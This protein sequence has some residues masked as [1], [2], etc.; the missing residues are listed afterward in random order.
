MFLEPLKHDTS[1]TPRSVPVCY[2]NNPLE[3]SRQ[4]SKMTS[5]F[6][7]RQAKALEGAG[8][9]VKLHRKRR[10]EKTTPFGRR[11][12]YTDQSLESALSSRNASTSG[13]MSISCTS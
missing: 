3:R 8:R 7:H 11:N 9:Y 5:S 2:P 12:L 10:H 1:E 6:L 13:R 4:L